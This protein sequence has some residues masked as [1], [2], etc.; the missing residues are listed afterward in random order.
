MKK[1]NKVVLMMLVFSLAFTLT[2]VSDVFAVVNDNP[3]EVLENSVIVAEDGI[4]INGQF[5]SQEE[6]ENLLAQAVYMESLSNELMESPNQTETVYSTAALAGGLVAGTWWIPGIGEIVITA[7]GAI[8]IG[9]TIIAAGTWVYN[10]VKAYFAEKAYEEAKENGTKAENH[11]N[12]STSTKTSLPTTGT[13]LSSTDLKDSQGVKQR[14]YYDKD[15]N[16]DLDIDYRHAGNYAFPHRH[17]WN[18]GKRSGH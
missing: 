15:G 17:T 3:S 6:F 7:A 1:I 16:A 2:G 9:G 4:V 14:R 12:Q 5:Y 10:T 18:N 13:P 11:S 8:I